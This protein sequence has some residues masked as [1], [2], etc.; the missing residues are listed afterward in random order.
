MTEIKEI[1]QKNADELARYFGVKTERLDTYDYERSLRNALL[2]RSIE[3]HNIHNLE[4]QPKLNIWSPKNAGEMDKLVKEF[5]AQ[6]DQSTKIKECMRNL[7]PYS[8]S[9]YELRHKRKL[10][11]GVTVLYQLSKEKFVFSVYPYHEYETARS[12]A[13][14]LGDEAKKPDIEREL[15]KIRNNSGKGTFQI[16]ALN[17]ECF[18][19]GKVVLTGNRELIAELNQI[20][21]NKYENGEYDHILIEETD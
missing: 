5:Y 4:E 17:F 2:A 10:P 20:I 1:V 14:F 13:F 9:S 11:D 8:V 12:L 7:R 19:N 6:F 15:T 18:K 21:K 16:G 3:R